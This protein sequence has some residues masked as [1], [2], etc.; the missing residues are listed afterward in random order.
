MEALT[1][2]IDDKIEL[3]EASTAFADAGFIN[4]NACLETV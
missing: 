4:R 3:M 1:E 2:L